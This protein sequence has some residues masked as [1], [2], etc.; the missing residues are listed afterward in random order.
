MVKKISERKSPDQIGLSFK[1]NAEEQKLYA[2]LKQKLNPGIYLKELAYKE[3][4]IETGKLQYIETDNLQNTSTSS[5]N[6]EP[7]KT[8]IAANPYGF[9]DDDD[10]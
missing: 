6:D 5:R 10:E 1:N 3:Y 9:D 2:W 8:E 4:L 7:T